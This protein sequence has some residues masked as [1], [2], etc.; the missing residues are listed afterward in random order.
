MQLTAKRYETRQTC[1]ASRSKRARSRQV[2]TIAH[3]S[4][5][6]VVALDRAC[7]IDIQVNGYG[8]QEFS[9]AE[10]TVEQVRTS[11]GLDEFGVVGFAP[12]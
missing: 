1:A 9:S 6:G 3:D 5:D 7:F 11:G 4:G 12:R 2:E 8:G 10:I